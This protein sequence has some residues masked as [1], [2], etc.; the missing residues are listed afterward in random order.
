MARIH[1]DRP[2]I[3]PLLYKS[4]S[5][6]GTMAQAPLQGRETI[7]YQILQ[8]WVYQTVANNPHLRKETPAK[9]AITT[10]PAPATPA[11]GPPPTTGAAQKPTVG[12]IPPPV[13][14]LAT[15]GLPLGNGSHPPPVFAENS[16]PLSLQANP[17]EI[18]LVPHDVQT[19]PAVAQ[20]ESMG[21][22][23][24]NDFNSKEHPNR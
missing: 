18:R 3:S 20:I 24:P 2:E 22:C 16:L 14:P 7:P 23:D 8:A 5:K 11:A 17:Q 1:F 21:V 6:H 15:P 9:L 12:L 13:V 4:I 10:P 19:L